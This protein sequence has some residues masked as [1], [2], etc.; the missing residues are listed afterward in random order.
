MIMRP[1]NVSVVFSPLYYEEHNGSPLYERDIEP[2][3]Q[4]H[5]LKEFEPP[6][7]T[8][9]AQQHH[10]AREQIIAKQRIGLHA[11]VEKG[12]FTTCSTFSCTDICQK[13]Y[14]ELAHRWRRKR[15]S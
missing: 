9:I 15:Q 6:L 11:V 7:R 8:S 10:V 2:T 1:V 5:M 12:L 3:F 4:P 14:G 13:I